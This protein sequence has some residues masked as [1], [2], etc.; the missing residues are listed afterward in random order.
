MEQHVKKQKQQKQSAADDQR[1]FHNLTEA[2]R[3]G[4]S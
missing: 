4:L 2:L 3:I 1:R